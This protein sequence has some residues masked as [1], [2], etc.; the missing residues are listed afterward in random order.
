[1]ALK[2]N[3]K[4]Y[5]TDVF[6]IEAQAVLHLIKL[7]DSNFDRTVDCILKCKGKVVVAG[8]G[9]SGIIARKIAATLASTGTPAFFLHPVEAFHGDLGMLQS[10]DVFIGISYSGNSSE[11]LKLLPILKKMKVASIGISGNKNSKLATAVDYNLNVQVEKEACPLEL[12]PTS[13]TAATMAMGDALAVALM[14]AR[15][16]KA[17]D[18]ALYHP[19]GALGAKLLNTVSDIMSSKNLPIVQPNT[20]FSNLIDITNRGKMGL[21]VVV[22]NK[23]VVGIITDGDLRRAMN[24]REEKVFHT[25]AKELMTAKPKSITANTKMEIAEKLMK[26]FNIT[27]LLVI[28]KNELKGI[29]QL[30]DTKQHD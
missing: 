24:Q 22:Q 23:K 29:V 8:V 19:G 2:T 5:A 28:D 13:S 6:E 26:Q 20:N 7:L 10:G 27:S 14:K 17:T 1:M 9:K 16:F 25:T 4:K 15:N 11:L 12:A 3:Y 18:F 21:A 30:H